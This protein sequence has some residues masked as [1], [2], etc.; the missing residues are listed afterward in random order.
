MEKTDKVLGIS[1]GDPGGVG[2]EIILK[3]F[4]EMGNEIPF[5]VIG[6]FSVLNLCKEKLFP[7]ENINLNIIKSIEEC[8]F[9]NKTLNVCDLNIIDINRFEIG[10]ISKNNGYASFKY[11]EKAIQMAINK[12]ISGV[13]TA[14]INKESINLAGYNFS[15]H[16]EIFAYYTNIEDYV[17]LL[18]D[19]KLKIS[20]VSTHVALLDC[21][22]N[23]KKERIL[24]VLE[25]SEKFLN[26]V[27]IKSPKIAV[28]GINPHASE[29]GLFGKEENEV[30]IPSINE[31]ILKSKG[32]V[33]GPES[34]DTVFL[35]ASEGKY[36]LVVAMYHD[37][38]HIPMKMLGF[39]NGVN[40]TLGLPIV[41]TSVDHGTAFDIS[42]KK[43][44]SNNSLNEAIKIGYKLS[45]VKNRGGD[46]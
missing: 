11:I 29:N 40:I 3:S 34:P 2:P 27:G 17:M 31:Y 37:Q 9:G 20:H 13:V 32:K 36:D 14:P 30:I 21:I 8:I 26:Q 10:K 33:S 25:L 44:A 7:N 42:W 28:S 38:G 39:D 23:L 4:L 45:F 43:I 6:D 1:M 41:R 5:I 19:E 35:K 18:Y 46:F 16:T 15:G 22:L 24:K 12:E